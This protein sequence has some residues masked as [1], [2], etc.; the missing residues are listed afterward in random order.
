MD[1]QKSNNILAGLG[2]PVFG[3]RFVGRLNEIRVLE[4][5]IIKSWSDNVSIVGLHK[6]GK[7]SLVLHTILSRKKELMENKMVIL[8]TQMSDFSNSRD[9]YLHLLHDI[10]DQMTDDFE[11]LDWG[12]VRKITLEKIVESTTIGD[13]RNI[14]KKTFK[15]IN[16]LAGFHTVLVLDEF[17]SAPQAFSREYEGDDVKE[18]FGKGEVDFQ[19][20]REL[21][22]M[23]N[24]YNLSLVTLS[25]RDLGIIEVNSTAPSLFSQIFGVPIHLQMFN[26]EDLSLYWKRLRD[27]YPLLTTD[28]RNKAEYMVGA[29][30]YLLDKYN[31]FCICHGIFD[32]PKDEDLAM[33]RKDT[34][35]LFQSILDRLDKDKL[36]KIAVQIV[37]GPVYENYEGA[38]DYLKLYGFLRSVP[39]RTKQRILGSIDGVVEGDGMDERGYICFSD[40]CTKKF[41]FDHY[42]ALQYWPLWNETEK[43]LRRLI[44]NYV[45]ECFSDNW[46]EEIVSY[47]D[48]VIP[49]ENFKTWLGNFNRLKK[50]REKAFLEFGEN[51]HAD[52]VDYTH[53]SDIYMT[54]IKNDWNW[55]ENILGENN[56]YWQSVFSYLTK[57]R[58]AH[59]HS[60][61][62]LVSEI[63]L[64]QASMYCRK[65]LD[66]IQSWERE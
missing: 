17:D 63:Q 5:R 50:E 7:T 44:K 6:V 60:N 42:S 65:I 26:S 9:F 12:R 18:E 29:H 21:G 20:L 23:S 35:A 41:S 15:K 52:L 55:F 49:E 8:Y 59:A 22:S 27:A 36:L 61:S 58:N 48:T 62:D 47:I 11:W 64:E 53:T 37:R 31:D 38:I 45:E 30:P 51:A 24:D 2:R 34:N 19:T 46:E 3:N 1:N 66:L 28:Y 25:R 33:I 40:Y 10:D 54:F 56:G 16:N 43:A 13:V 14:V 4:D 39:T 57:I 32:K